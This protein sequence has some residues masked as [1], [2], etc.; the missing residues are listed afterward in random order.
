M[1]AKIALYEEKYEKLKTYRKDNR[2][3]FRRQMTAKL[4]T[5]SLELDEFELKDFISSFK[6]ELIQ[7]SY[8][9][10]ESLNTILLHLL[11]Y[12]PEKFNMIK[13]EIYFIA[14][15]GDIKTLDILKNFIKEKK[16]MH[17]AINW[18]KSILKPLEDKIKRI[19]KRLEDIKLYEME[20]IFDQ[21]VE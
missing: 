9:F 18:I 2:E 4:K 15:I 14:Q 12:K 13:E 7:E 19:E 11:K 16:D 8:F 3:E 21:W 6:L 5:L 17:D 1:S 10:I 20:E